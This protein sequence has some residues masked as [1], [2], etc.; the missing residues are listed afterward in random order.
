MRR[1]KTTA[2]RAHQMRRLPHFARDG[3]KPGK[4]QQD[5]EQDLEIGVDDDKAAA[6]IDV[7]VLDDA[8]PHQEQRE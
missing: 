3:A 2:R 6:G 1:Q 4:D 5:A 8:G 7:E